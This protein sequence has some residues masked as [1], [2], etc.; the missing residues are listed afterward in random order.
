MGSE[1]SWISLTAATALCAITGV[2][3]TVLI[4]QTAG[5]RESPVFQ[6][7]HDQADTLMALHLIR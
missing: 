7:N 3:L 6:F 5:M 1:P 4:A 2:L